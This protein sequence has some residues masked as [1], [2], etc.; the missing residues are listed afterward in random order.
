MPFICGLCLFCRLYLLIEGQSEM[1]VKYAKAEIE[2]A[3]E[4]ET[5]KISAA[6]S[7]VGGARYGML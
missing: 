7:M 1:E 2:K 3:L 6:G 4:M 5:L